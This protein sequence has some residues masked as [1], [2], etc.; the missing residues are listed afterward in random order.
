LNQVEI[1]VSADVDTS[2]SFVTQNVQEFW[3]SELLNFS[4]AV[5]GEEPA[6]SSH[7]LSQKVSQSRRN[8]FFIAAIIV[9]A[10]VLLLQVLKPSAQVISMSA[11]SVCWACARRWSGTEA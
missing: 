9:I 11:L 10:A 4:A 8:Y 3:N 2:G 1:I 5:N 7:D 6:V